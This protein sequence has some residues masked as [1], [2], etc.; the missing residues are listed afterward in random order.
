MTAFRFRFTRA[1]VAFAVLLLIAGS[2]FAQATTTGAI[3]G[4][5]TT[6]DG[7][8]IPGVTVTVTSPVLQGTRTAYSGDNGDY[9]IRG[10][11]P[12]N[13]TAEF[14]MEGMAP[15]KRS[16][17]VEL[18][19]MLEARRDDVPLG[20]ERGHHR[21]GRRADAA[22]H[23]AARTNLNSEQLQELPIP[24]GGG[25]LANIA[26]LTPGVTQNTFNAGQVRI[27]GAFGY[28]NVF[29]VDGTDVNDNLFGTAH[30]LFIEDAI[31]ETQVLTGGVSAEYGRFT[32]GVVNVVTKSGGN[33]FT[34]SVRADLTNSVVARRDADRDRGPSGARTTRSTPAPSAVRSSATACGSSSPAAA[35]KHRDVADPPD[36][37][38][39]L[40]SPASRTRATKES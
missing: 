4:T 2:A 35:K 32:G 17:E 34:G 7:V 21:H 6:S 30:N 23:H 13:Y 9:I 22:H 1:F 36:T 38:L 15:I 5:T 25:F 37:S 8:A 18:G 10:L 26:S 29:L 39:R 14:T 31:Q 19:Q 33:E 27:N 24:R 40:H 16:L 11:P 12:G 3:S 20:D 28:D